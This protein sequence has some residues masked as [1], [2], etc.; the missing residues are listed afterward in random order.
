MEGPPQLHG[1]SH[2]YLTSRGLRMHVALAGAE[3]SP[4]VMLV[5][6]WPQNW[7]TW[8]EVIEELAST[9][10]VIA[11]DLRGHGW[12]DAPRSGYRK[13]VL[14]SDLLGALDVL[15]IERMTWVGHDWGGWIGLIAGLR[16]PE[17]FE[18]MLT[19]CV[20]HLWTR[21]APRHVALLSYQ[22]PV[23]LPLLG[24]HLAR[25]LVPSILQSGRG[26]DPLSTTD[27]EVF[28]QHMPAHVSTA[29]YRT[30]LTRELLPL[31]RGRYARSVLEVPTTLIVGVRD[32]VTR[33]IVAGP[34]PGQP[35]LT[36]Q[37]LDGAAHWIPEQ[38]PE[39]VV[40]WVRSR[41]TPA[42]ATSTRELTSRQ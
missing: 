8:R 37:V 14:A 5:H 16:A 7:W 15:G 39:V 6:G 2:R 25:R 23:S 19:L 36:A 32:L 41:T 28:A 34:V 21:L 38:R 29:M 13:E 27:V 33:G 40:D 10:R 3:D 11:P 20:P 12:T 42:S 1:V 17:R 31:A 30:F 9:N 22:G 4:A 35:R 26:R 24:P 18:R